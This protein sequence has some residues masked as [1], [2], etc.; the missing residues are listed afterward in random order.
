MHFL[1][2]NDIFLLH[3]KYLF[4]LYFK[5]RRS[6]SK[7]ECGNCI[8]N[9]LRES[10]ELKLK[11]TAVWASKGEGEVYNFKSGFNFYGKR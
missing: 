5:G 7:H 9:F 8:H 3:F 6:G 10:D 2:V 1:Y 11:F 4:T